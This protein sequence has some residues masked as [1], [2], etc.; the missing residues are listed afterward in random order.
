MTSVQAH[1]DINIMGLGETDVI[2]LHRAGGHS[3]V[4]VFFF[5]GGQ[6]FGNRAHFPSHAADD[7]DGMT[8]QHVLVDA[9]IA[10][11]SVIT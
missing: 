7:S 11:N 4:Q 3:C 8:G 2:A 1:Q 5:R 10:Q 9:G 6:N